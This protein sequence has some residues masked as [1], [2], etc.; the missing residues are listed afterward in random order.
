[1]QTLQRKPRIFLSHS[2]KDVDFVRKLEADLRACQCETWIDEVEIRHGKPWMDEIFSKG[3]P[4]CEIVL[5]YITKDSAQ[6][7]MVKKEID[8]R[9]IERLANEHVTLLI[10]VANEE[11]RSELRI[12]IQAL[13]IPVFNNENYQK[14]LP[15]VV[16]EIWRS[17]SDAAIP[18]AIQTEKIRRLELE[19]KVKDLESQSYR[20]TF[21]A[22]ETSEFNAVW[23][24]IDRRFEAKVYISDNVSKASL[25]SA[26]C[27]INFGILYRQTIS[28]QKFNPSDYHMKNKIGT[29]LALA[30]SVSSQNITTGCNIEFD[31]EAELLRFGFLQRAPRQIQDRG[32]SIIN[33]MQPRFELIFT[34]KFDRF[35]LW[36]DCTFD[37]LNP[38]ESVLAE[39][40]PD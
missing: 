34:E 18:Q 25:A 21:S 12:D 39:V 27:L 38:R 24:Q 3:M 20:D 30:R 5:C 22:K 36:I 7:V 6:S 16:A 31:Y 13:Q 1:M 9:L 14:M 8:A 10:Y 23:K 26:T 15:K 2:K 33:S 11:L 29:D 4:S 40:Y 37:Q 35:N 32:S 19:L 28:T 17:Y